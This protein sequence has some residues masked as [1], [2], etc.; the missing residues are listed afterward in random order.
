VRIGI[1]LMGGDTPP[2]LLF[3]AVLQA[4]QRLG[5]PF[6]FTVLATSSVIE[7]LQRLQKHPS[8][9]SFLAAEEVISMD[10]EPLTAIRRKTRSTLIEGITL[11]K[12]GE[13][14]AFVSCGNTGA[15]VAAA[16]LMLPRIKGVERPALLAEIPT[17]TGTVAI[18]DVGGNVACKAEH[19]VSYAFLGADYVRAA[20]GIVR[21]RVAL[22]NIGTE[23]GKG[24]GE[25]REAYRLLEHEQAFD[26]CGNI[27]GREIF[28]GKCDVIVTDGF[29]GNI[30][31]KTA[32]GVSEYL[33]ECLRQEQSIK[34][35]VLDKLGK[36][37]DYTRHQGALVCGV[38]GLVFKV[39]GNADAGA[40]L[41]TILGA[42]EARSA[43]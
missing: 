34:A 3:P 2:D 43:R 33:F 19:L 42:A 10:D 4:M 17:A 23:A 29:S 5:D 14:D 39:H 13:I 6:S 27:E 9:L 18:L 35:D 21:P 15:L 41:A 24:T 1:D 30:M 31:L 7:A 25:V 28:R 37:F 36:K 38:E 40:L 32:E 8:N 20:H 22:L 26:F 11:L 16:T 12:K